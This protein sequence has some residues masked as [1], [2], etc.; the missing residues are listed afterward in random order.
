MLPRVAVNTHE[1]NRVFLLE[2]C[3]EQIEAKSPRIPFFRCTCSFGVVVFFFLHLFADRPRLH[4]LVFRATVLT[5]FSALLFSVTHR[6]PRLDY[7]PS[8]PTNIE[9][10]DVA[11]PPAVGQGPAGYRVLGSRSERGLVS[12]L[13]LRVRD[14]QRVGIWSSLALRYAAL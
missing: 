6:F 10:P 11:R 7:A 2:G 14:N 8:T 12:C 13:F 1:S 5:L 3:N 9:Q 4:E